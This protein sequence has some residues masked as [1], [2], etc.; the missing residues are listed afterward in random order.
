MKNMKGQQSYTTAVN[1]PSATSLS[2][3]MLRHDSMHLAETPQPAR[4]SLMQHPLSFDWRS[5]NAR[6][7]RSN[8]HAD[9]AEYITPSLEQSKEE[10]ERDTVERSAEEMESLYDDSALLILRWLDPRLAQVLDDAATVDAKLLCAHPALLSIITN[11]LMQWCAISSKEFKN[12]VGDSVRWKILP[13]LLL[14]LMLR[15][16]VD[17]DQEV[18]P[19]TTKSTNEGSTSSIACADATVSV[20]TQQQTVGD[21]TNAAA[22][23]TDASN[24]KLADTSTTSDTSTGN[25]LIATADTTTASA[26][27]GGSTGTTTSTT[28]TATTAALTRST[29]PEVIAC[30][31]V[32]SMIPPPP[33]AQILDGRSDSIPS[34]GNHVD[35]SIRSAVTNDEAD[36]DASSSSSTAVSAGAVDSSA[37][38]NAG[39]TGESVCTVDGGV[40]SSLG[41][42][43]NFIG[44]GTFDIEKANELLNLFC[45]MV[46]VLAAVGDSSERITNASTGGTVATGNRLSSSAPLSPRGT[47]STGSPAVRRFSKVVQSGSS[48]A[49]TTN[50]NKSRGASFA[51]GGSSAS[52]F[53]RSV[54]LSQSGEDVWVTTFKVKADDNNNRITVMND[55]SDFNNLYRSLKFGNENPKYGDV[56][57]N[58]SSSSNVK[59]Y[60]VEYPVSLRGDEAAAKSAFNRWLLGNIWAQGD[61]SSFEE[62]KEH[63]PPTVAW[64]NNANQQLECNSSDYSGSSSCDNPSDGAQ[65]DC[66]DEE[67]ADGM[68]DVRRHLLNGLIANAGKRSA[69]AGTHEGCGSESGDNAAPFSLFGS[70]MGLHMLNSAAG[71]DALDT[72]SNSDDAALDRLRKTVLQCKHIWPLL[73]VDKDFEAA[74]TLVEKPQHDQRMKKQRSVGDETAAGA[75]TAT[76]SRF[77]ILGRGRR[78]VSSAS[79]TPRLSVNTYSLGSSKTRFTDDNEEFCS[80]Y[81]SSNSGSTNSQRRRRSSMYE[82][83][84]SSSTTNSGTASGGSMSLPDSKGGARRTSTQLADEWESGLSFSGSS[85][86][87]TGGLNKSGASSRRGS[88]ATNKVDDE[89]MNGDAGEGG[90]GENEDAA[91]AMLYGDE[92]DEDEEAYDDGVED[93]A[94]YPDDEEG[95]LPY[96][97]SRGGFAKYRR[98]GARGRYGRIPMAI[99]EGNEIASGISVPMALPPARVQ[100][101]PVRGICWNAAMSRWIVRWNEDGRERRRHF[102]VR[103]GLNGEDTDCFDMAAAYQKAVELRLEME[104]AFPGENFSGRLKRRRGRGRGSRKS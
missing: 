21:P 38:V 44:K 37:T 98:G 36:M 41:D 40:S 24:T 14:S 48:T 79:S 51:S 7:S 52:A 46:E 94:P 90:Q 56:D 2:P 60:N 25:T 47:S 45:R 74:A 63:A 30:S 100:D 86:S 91:N 70:S 5:N 6:G 32:S 34:D 4:S 85:A 3:T 81:D 11:T 69:S 68:G 95:W 31:T 29:P 87:S 78:R 59:T 54:A 1:M 88:R 72:A 50:V 55:K 26:P 93:S 61:W 23:P 28:N 96:N 8:G 62:C 92:I 33:S 27:S 84:R 97:R 103:T 71:D 19:C 9:V 43:L 58:S 67:D 64:Y 102:R 89:V 13:V 10:D 83:R 39:G 77:S 49:A 12:F 104:T 99:K 15:A 82:E 57:S 35:T 17:H 18:E 66:N 65:E 76:G 16:A 80:D 53:G 22:M 73:D 20:S 42:A 101:R 75:N